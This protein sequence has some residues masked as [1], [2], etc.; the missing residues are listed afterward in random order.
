MPL[1]RSSLTPALLV[2]ADAR[3][4]R[5]AANSSTPGRGSSYRSEGCLNGMLFHEHW[6]LDA[7]TNG[8]FQEATVESGGH[9]V[10]RLPYLLTK[11][12]GFTYCRMPPFTHVLGPVV[13]A[14]PGK[15]QTQLLKRLSILR[16]L[17]EQ[18]PP[19]DVFIH[20]LDYTFIDG[21][22]FQE[23]GF[24]ITPQYTFVVDCT[25]DEETLWKGMHFKTR[26]HIRR[27]QE[28]LSV[29]EIDDPNHFIDFYLGNLQNRGLRNDIEFATF[30]EVFRQ[31]RQRD[32][33]EVL[34]ARR[35]DGTPAAMVFLV[36][37][38]GTMYYT[39]STRAGDAC[40]NGSINLLIWSAMQRAHSRGL[41]FDL[42]G[43]SSNGTARFLSGFNGAP[44]L[45]F[46]VKRT[47]TVYGAMLT[48]KRRLFGQHKSHNFT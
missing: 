9:I 6:W 1:D 11:R 46:V 35:P 24:E 42:D 21:L 3:T 13:D 2:T 44:K 33:G 16:Q 34:C 45:R 40:D 26:Q 28:N 15:P 31:S 23:L 19:S 17:I 7:T 43:V 36:W 8:L 48:A 37:G 14:G 20:A 22:A 12:M 47:S 41:Q 27:A 4:V 29:T 30:P 10:G 38:Y 25:K 39:L 18:L 32:S 5:P